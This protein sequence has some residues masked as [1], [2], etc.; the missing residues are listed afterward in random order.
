MQHRWLIV[1][2]ALAAAGCGGATRDEGGT[3]TAQVA[4]EPEQQS[5][6]PNAEPAEADTA[7]TTAAAG[8]APAKVENPSTGR[9]TEITLTIVGNPDWAGTYH[10]AGTSSYCGAQPMPVIGD[11]VFAVEFPDRGDFEISS[12]SFYAD[13]LPAGG[14]TT[15]RYNMSISLH[16]KRIGS[17][18]AF[19]VN[20]KL[21]QRKESG[22]A[23]LT[24]DG[25]TSRLMVQ[26]RSSKGT[27]EMTVVCK[28]TAA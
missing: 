25:G 12:L 20:T 26:G 1:V 15:T 3:D 5:T 11:D 14:G 10:A 9:P 19:V 4:E 23:T 13:T 28:P 8:A 21:A 18:P 7:T 2:L 17:P 27:V 16:N 22:T 6:D 24:A